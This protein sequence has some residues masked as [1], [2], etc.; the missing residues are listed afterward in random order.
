MLTFNWIY[1]NK[2]IESCY[3]VR[4]AVFVDE[5]G[6]DGENEF[7]DIDSI[8]HHLEMCKNGVI[9]GTARVFKEHADDIA[10]HCGRI[11]ILKDYRNDGLGLVLMEHVK[12]KI[13]ELG[14][15]SIELSAQVRVKEFY[16]KAGYIE[17]GH[18]YLDEGCPHIMMQLNLSTFHNRLL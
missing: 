5:Q 3:S 16:K 18:Q 4:K 8:S 13:Q 7:D 11:C 15:A 17:F 6:F 2:N 12:S 10:Y 9:I 1:G 14:G